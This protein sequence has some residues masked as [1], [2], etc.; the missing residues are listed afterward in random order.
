MARIKAWTLD[1]NT[2]EIQTVLNNNPSFVF[3]RWLNLADDL[4]AIGA[5]GVSLSP[6]RS[7]AA[8]AAYTP[9]GAPIWLE[10]QTLNGAFNQL[11]LAQDVGSA[12]KGAARVDIYMGTG[13]AAGQLAS[14]QK[15]PAKVW[16]LLPKP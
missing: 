2:A 7:V 10:T 12:I 9:L 13:E 5:L 14:A 1:K 11:M 3:F 15:Y 16:V 8:D 4:G 6:M